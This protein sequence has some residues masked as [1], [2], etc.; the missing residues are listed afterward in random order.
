ME[1]TFTGGQLHI[2]YKPALIGK[3]GDNIQ[4][5]IDLDG[6]SEEDSVSFGFKIQEINEKF[7]ELGIFAWV[8]CGYKGIEP[9]AAANKIVTD[10]IEI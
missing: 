3:E 2:L 10:N 9:G 8:T 1:Y 5:D 6:M 7:K 4:S